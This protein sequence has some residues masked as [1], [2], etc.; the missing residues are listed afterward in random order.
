MD[1]ENEELEKKRNDF[2]KYATKALAAEQAGDTETYL[3]NLKIATQLMEEIEG[4]SAREI[5]EEEKMK[6]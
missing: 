4:K 1:M 3:Y 6:R 5:D 2:I